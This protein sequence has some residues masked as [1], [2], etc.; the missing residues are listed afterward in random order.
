MHLRRFD[1]NPILTRAD[2]PSGD[3]RLADPSSVFNPGAVKDG[4]TY[5][6]LL[7]V[8]DRGRRT[9]LLPAGGA[10]GMDFT[11]A[12]RPL[13]LRGAE[14]LAERAHHFYDPRITLLDG[15]FYIMLAVDFDRDCRLGLAVTDDFA[16]CEFLG[17]VSGKDVR[18]G[19][20]FPERVDG[21]YLR[22]ERPN[23]IAFPGGGPSGNEIVLSESSDLLAWNAIGTVCAGRPHYWDELIGPG[24]PPVKR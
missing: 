13:E 19:V 1:G 3:P 14:K 9:R 24:P 23:R 5:R 12:P 20:L 2:M 6:L 8:Q 15:R 17:I 22:L 11:V 18:N 16:D 10:N 7:R 4:D 21:R